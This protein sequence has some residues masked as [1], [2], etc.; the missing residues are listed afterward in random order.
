MYLTDTKIF[1]EALLDQEKA[2]DVRDILQ[3][4]EDGI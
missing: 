2:Q 3:E 4:R 1:L